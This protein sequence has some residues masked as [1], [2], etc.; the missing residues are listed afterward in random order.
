MPVLNFTELTTTVGRPK[1]VINTLCFL[2]WKIYD[3]FH[4]RVC[5]VNNIISSRKGNMHGNDNIYEH[6]AV[7]D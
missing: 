1:G 4:Y 5:L 6:F 2:T 7:L 3:N